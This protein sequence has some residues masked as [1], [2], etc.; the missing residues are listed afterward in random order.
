[1]KPK[2]YLTVALEAAVTECLIAESAAFQALTPD[3]RREYT[4]LAQTPEI[5]WEALSYRYPQDHAVEVL[6]IS[7]AFRTSVA[8][9]QQRIARG[10]LE[11]FS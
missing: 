8:A 6:A 7:T 1:M 11:D 9:L 10:D 5:A 2:Q 4:E 3:L